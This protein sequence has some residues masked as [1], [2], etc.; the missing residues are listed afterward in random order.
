MDDE[1]RWIRKLQ[2]HGSRSAAEKLVAAHYDEIYAYAYRQTGSKEDAMDLTQ[3]IFIAALRAIG[4][5]DPSRASFRTWLYR[6]A[7][8]KIIDARRRAR[9]PEIP[10]DEISLPAD[11]DFVRMLED[12]DLL[13]AVETFVSA[14]SPQ[15]QR[16]FR[17]RLYGE[18]SFPE[19]AAVCA[20]SESAVKSRFHRMLKQ[21]RKEFQDYGEI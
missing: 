12:K 7:S 10:L 11:E 6:I 13:R 18:L 20:E 2:R 19:I 17:L 8:N 16:V 1:S 9:P 21:L 3:T 14:Q 15:I 4:S 5:Y